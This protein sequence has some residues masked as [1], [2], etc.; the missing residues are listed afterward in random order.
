[1]WIHHLMPATHRYIVTLAALETISVIGGRVTPVPAGLIALGLLIG[2][3]LLGTLITLD[4]DLP[5]G[6]SNPNGKQRPEWLTGI[7]HLNLWVCQGALVLLAFAFDARES[8][9][10]VF[11]LT[12]AAV[13]LGAIGFPRVL[14]VISERSPA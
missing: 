10:N 14:A 13:V 9:A 4:D 12:G 8:L 3:P 2:W 5:G 7:W 11:A 6:W 1:M